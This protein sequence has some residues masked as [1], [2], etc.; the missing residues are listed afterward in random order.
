MYHWDPGLNVAECI[1]ATWASLTG[2]GMDICSL[3]YIA[4]HIRSCICK[5]LH[6]APPG[7]QEEGAV[8]A[9]AQAQNYPLAP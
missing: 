3:T 2:S 6:I 8:V 1:T 4:V 7:P 9:K 5:N